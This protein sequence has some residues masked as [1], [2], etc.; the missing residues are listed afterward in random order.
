LV[1]GLGVVEGA[2]AGALFS[3]GPGLTA[4]YRHLATLIDKMFKGARPAD[5]PVEQMNIYELVVNLK[6]ARRLGIE[7]PRSFLLQATQTIE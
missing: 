1:F 4:V 2:I 7:L 5:I 3:Y 6:T